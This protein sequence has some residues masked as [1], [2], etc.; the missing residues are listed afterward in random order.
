M[1]TVRPRA[2]LRRAIGAVAL[3]MLPACRTWQAAPAPAPASPQRKLADRAKVRLREGGT[4]VELTALIVAGDSVIGTS[5]SPPPH[6]VAIAVT[7]IDA[8]ETLRLHGMR[9]AGTALVVTM[10]AATIAL[11]VIVVEIF[12]AF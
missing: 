11:S 7:D 6:R 10:V 5:V 8:V 4:V 2:R 12:H 1:R 9:T 3:T